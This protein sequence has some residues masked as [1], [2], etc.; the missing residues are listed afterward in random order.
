MGGLP[1]LMAVKSLREKVRSRAQSDPGLK[2]YAGQWL[3]VAAGVYLGIVFFRS[4][5]G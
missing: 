3:L 2:P 5:V 1:L 4:V